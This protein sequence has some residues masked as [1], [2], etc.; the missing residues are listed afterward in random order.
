MRLERKANKHSR[1]AE[2]E[3]MIE[4]HDASLRVSCAPTTL[5]PRGLCA[6]G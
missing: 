2:M 6:A 4:A 3:T 5:G 1:A